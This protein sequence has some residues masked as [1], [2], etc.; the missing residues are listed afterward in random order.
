MEGGGRG[1]FLFL[2]LP[3]YM[4]INWITISGPGL[5]VTRAFSHISITGCMKG[6]IDGGVWFGLDSFVPNPSLH[7]PHILLQIIFE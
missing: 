2:C 3:A 7:I 6:W 5:L 1:A 4:D